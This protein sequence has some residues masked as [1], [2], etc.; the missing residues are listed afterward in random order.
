MWFAARSDTFLRAWAAAGCNYLGIGVIWM[1][2]SSVRGFGSLFAR[3]RAGRWRWLIAAI[4]ASLVSV[5]V[6]GAG[7]RVG[8][9]PEVDAYH[10]GPV[11]HS[12]QAGLV[13]TIVTQLAAG[14]ANKAGSQ[15]FGW[16]LG[17]FGLGDGLEN[18]IAGIRDQLREIQNRLNEILAATT[19]IRA[20]LAESTYSGLVA[21]TTPITAR[22]DTG[23]NDLKTV[24]DMAKGDPTKAAFTRATLAYI[25]QKLMGGEQ[26]ELA[27]RITGEAGAD[28]LIVAASKVAK[29]ASPYWTALTSQ[30]VRQVFDYYQQQEARLLLL[31][32]EYMHANPRTYSG[33]TIAADIKQVENELNTQDGLLKPSP[34]ANTVADTRDNLLWDYQY[35]GEKFTIQ[36]ARFFGGGG[37][38]TTCWRP[39]SEDTIRKFVQGWSGANWA[40]W[41]N[42][43]VDG[44]ITQLS[45]VNFTGVWTYAV[46]FP[47]ATGIPCTARAFRA[48]LS[49]WG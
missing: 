25:K 33:D 41:L 15:G 32:V 36:E 39:A 35:I 45:G 20:D 26:T 18:D 24:A 34:P 17:Q 9:A 1:I 16:V 38:C 7:N 49:V 46:C 3:A 12:A 10:R 43:Q 30:R 42:R 13:L 11:A 19:Q 23:L 4:V 21:Q 6:A 29:T 37:G 27:K 31:R 48:L 22:I 14:A 2:R 40:E 5:P 28:G 47:P 44:Q 8:R